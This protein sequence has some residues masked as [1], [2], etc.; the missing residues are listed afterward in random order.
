[1]LLITGKS[2][3]SKKL[4]A[5]EPIDV[6]LVGGQSNA[7]GQGYLKNLPGD[8]IIDTSVIIFH[9]GLPHLNS[10]KPPLTWLPLRQASESPDRFGPEIGFGIRVHQLY[11]ERNIGIIKHAH[12]GTNLYQEWW[13]GDK[14]DTAE[15]GDQF[16]NFVFTVE[17]G[18]KALKKL[19][20]KPKIKAM[21]WQQGEADADKGGEIARAYGKNLSYFISRIRER[22]NTPDL[23]FIYG[24]VYPPPNKSE[25]IEAVRKAQ[26]DIDQNSGSAIAVRRA[27]V[28]YT[29]DLNHRADD[30]NSPYPN[31]HIHFGT[32]G[33]LELGKRMAE[34]VKRYDQ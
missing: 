25:G 29:D 23:L 13:P 15:W 1:M 14:N 21:L 26:K 18:L 12:S 19:G 7:T 5:Q 27:H 34:V 16:K 10:G 11:S 22:F 20:Y 31:D 28:I 2:I 8:F 33:M 17:L 24:Y 32:A 4:I 9:S 30:P 6:Y 3:G